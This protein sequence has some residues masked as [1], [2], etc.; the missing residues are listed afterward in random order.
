MI[1]VVSEKDNLIKNNKNDKYD[2]TVPGLTNVKPIINN[3]VF[4]CQDLQ[5]MILGV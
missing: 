4:G 1:T 3:L 2:S 5:I